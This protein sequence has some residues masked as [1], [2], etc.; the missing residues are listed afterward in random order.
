MGRFGKVEFDALS[1]PERVVEAIWRLDAEVWNG[2][3]DQYYFNSSGNDAHFAVRALETIG[4]D[5]MAAIV[6]DGIYPAAFLPPIRR[7]DGPC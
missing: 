2:G 1:V 3:F 4:A 7:R 5:D 6:R